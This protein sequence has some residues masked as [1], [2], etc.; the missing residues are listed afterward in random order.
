MSFTYEKGEDHSFYTGALYISFNSHNSSMLLFP[1]QRCGNPN[2]DRSSN[3]SKVM[4]YINK[5]GE[6]EPRSDSSTHLLTN[7]SQSSDPALPRA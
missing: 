6:F 2:S 7:I 4:Q 5:G 1:F 3:L